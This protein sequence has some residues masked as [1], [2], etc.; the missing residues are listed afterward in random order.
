MTSHGLHFASL[1]LC[2]SLLPALLPSAAGARPEQ[3]RPGEIYYSDDYV[4]QGG[5]RDLSGEKNYEEVYQFYR[6]YEAIY[7]EAGRVKSFKEFVRGELV[8]SESYRY[9]TEGELIEKRVSRPGA[10]DEVTRPGAK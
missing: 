5:V 3:A 7:D 6:Y 8:R 1:F 9:D 2:F 10:G 4:E